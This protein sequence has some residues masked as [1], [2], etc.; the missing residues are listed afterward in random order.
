M[1]L[2]KLNIYLRL[3]II[4]TGT[5]QILVRLWQKFPHT[6]LNKFQKN[7]SLFSITDLIFLTIPCP[8]EY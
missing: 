3:Y 4:G 6:I 7:I 5:G 1:L 2:Y 8:G